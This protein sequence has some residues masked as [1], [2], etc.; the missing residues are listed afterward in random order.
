MVVEEDKPNKSAKYVAWQGGDNLRKK[1]RQ[2][3]ENSIGFNCVG[4]TITDKS[5]T[6]KAAFQ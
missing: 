3:R 4:V 1:I 2:G 5:S 6:E